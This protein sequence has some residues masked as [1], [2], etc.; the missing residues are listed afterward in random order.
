MRLHWLLGEV[1]TESQ[2]T[3]DAVLHFYECLRITE[4]RNGLSGNFEAKVAIGKV[5]LSDSLLGQ[6][7]ACFSEVLF[8]ATTTYGCDHNEVAKGLSGLAKV[9]SRSEPK[10][11]EDLLRESKRSLLLRSA[12]L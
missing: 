8:T 4:E 5:Y 12:L 1:Y 9:Y 3:K 2:Q 6:A 7:K 11:A 10:R